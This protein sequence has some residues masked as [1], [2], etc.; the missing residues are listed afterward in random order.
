[1]LS[2]QTRTW[3][4]APRLH[5]RSP[6]LRF[7]R[8][9]Q[10]PWV[11]L[12][13]SR[14]LTFSERL[15]RKFLSLLSFVRWQVPWNI[16]TTA[17]R[18]SL[19]TISLSISSCFLFS[20]G[21]SVDNPVM[22]PPGRARLA[23]SPETNRIASLRHHDGNRRSGRSSP[24]GSGVGPDATIRS[25]FRRTNS[26]ARSGTRSYFP[27][28]KRYSMTMLFP[29]IQPSSRQPSPERVDEDRI[30]RH[31]CQRFRKPIRGI[32]LAAAPERGAPQGRTATTMKS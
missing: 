13:S 32:F 7:E 4:A 12:D 31:R 6:L 28:A 24:H 20:S 18:E 14:Y 9:S 25:T 21:D 11:L 8:R 22:F 16:P 5:N 30:D 29:S 23:T 1:M 27:S 3:G 17:T 15:S 19:G 10:C 2:A 26:A